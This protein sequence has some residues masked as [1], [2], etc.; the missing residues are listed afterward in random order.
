MQP[1]C[2]GGKESLTVQAL[3]DGFRHNE[4]SIDVLLENQLCLLRRC[5]IC[6]N[7][8]R[9]TGMSWPLNASPSI[10]QNVCSHEPV[11][12]PWTLLAGVPHSV[13][14]WHGFFSTLFLIQ[15]FPMPTKYPSVGLTELC[16][17]TTAAQV[18]INSHWEVMRNLAVGVF[19][20]LKLAGL[21]AF[22]MGEGGVKK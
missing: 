10:H 11:N 4:S 21:C 17:V 14:L 20:Q 16:Q 2:L 13:S 18:L 7:K 1:P 15:T 5:C 3:P 22:C 6:T 19:P 8:S 9:C 12:R